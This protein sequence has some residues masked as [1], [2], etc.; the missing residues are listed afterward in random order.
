MVSKDDN[1]A[2]GAPLFQYTLAESR[3]KDPQARR[4]R[5]PAP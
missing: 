2:A 1:G 4:I 3:F 5:V